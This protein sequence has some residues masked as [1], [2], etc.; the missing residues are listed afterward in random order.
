MLDS[1]K[2]NNVSRK[3]S[4]DVIVD[5]S[6]VILLCDT[7]SL[8]C[9][10]NLAEIPANKWSTQYKLYIKD[11]TNNCSVNNITVIAPI[12]FKVNNS[13]SLI[14]NTN[15]VSALIEITTNTDYCC[16]IAFASTSITA[17]TTSN[18][19]TIQSVLLPIVGG[20]NLS[21]NVKLTDY[22]LAGLN[23]ND[24]GVNYFPKTPIYDGAGVILN[25]YFS[26]LKYAQTLANQQAI[27]GYNSS[28]YGGAFTSSNLNVTTGEI[29][30][31]SNGLY[32]VIIRIR[33]AMA[34][35]NT[36]VNSTISSNPSTLGQSWNSNTAVKKTCL[37]KAGI[38]DYLYN[39]IGCETE[40]TLT[41]CGNFVI[42]TSMV[43]SYTTG[44]KLRGVFINN[45]DL[46]VYGNVASTSDAQIILIKLSE[47]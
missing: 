6:D 8:P 33:I 43:R 40:K 30:I 9:N 44:S 14:I 3:V 41:D 15:G 28:Q 29:T 37:F 5:N 18:T 11:D 39:G 45:T 25:T 20:Y 7:T 31:P 46:D 21:A 23:L 36:G 47:I 16:T 4:G 1:N 34:T 10:I 32:L 27:T 42:N 17:L 13:N 19:S 12:G 22:I 35:S 38:Y 24:N 2:Y 26:D